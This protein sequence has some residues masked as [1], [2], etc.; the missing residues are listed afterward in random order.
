MSQALSQNFEIEYSA[1]GQECALEKIEPS[2]ARLWDENSAVTKAS[3]VNLVI[4]SREPGSLL[5]N[6]ALGA[7]LTREHACRLVVVEAALA[8]D[9]GPIAPRAWITA[10]CQL[11][12]GNA[13]VCSEQI[14][15]HL[16]GNNLAQMRH[17]V[18]AHLQSDLPVVVWWQVFPGKMF[19][20]RFTS[21]I[22]RLVIDTSSWPEAELE[23][24]WKRVEEAAAAM[25]RPFSVNDLS[26]TRSYSWRLAVASIFDHPHAQ[27]GLPTVSHVIIRHREDRKV[28]AWFFAAWIAHTL[29]LQPTPDDPSAW[30][31]RDGRVVRFS[32]DELPDGPCLAAVRLEFE[33][34]RVE[35]I[36]EAGASRL[37]G[38]VED[39]SLS[40][41]FVFPVGSEDDASLVASQLARGNK[42]SL[43]DAVVPSFLRFAGISGEV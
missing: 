18:L 22:D 25:V 19:E 20:D 16:D 4:L 9:G 10:H 32:F 34:G 42:T 12:G 8:P 28:T 21:L 36:H 5:R 15:M 24:G 14:A 35:L 38:L 27:A 17:A 41:S 31:S 37:V 2:L 13:T 23:T 40:A 30:K 39:A 29:R 1:L 6:H 26:W 43:H 3:L 11:A 7:R 33:H